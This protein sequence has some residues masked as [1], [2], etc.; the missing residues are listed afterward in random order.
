MSKETCAKL[1]GAKRLM[2]ENID[3]EIFFQKYILSEETKTR[4]E[5][6]KEKMKDNITQA[7]PMWKTIAGEVRLC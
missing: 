4:I 3:S 1:L 6:I 2:R 5:S 7:N